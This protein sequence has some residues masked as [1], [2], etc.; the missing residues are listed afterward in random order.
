MVLDIR[1]L[2]AQFGAEI[3]GYDLTQPA[4][5]LLGRIVDAWRQARVVVLRG[6]GHAS[7]A[8]LLQFSRALGRLD[9]APNFDTEKSS[10]DGFAEIAVVSNIKREG[11]PLGG[12]GDGELAWHSD[13]TYVSDPP[14]ACALLARELPE[15]GS[16]DTWFL[17]LVGAYEALPLGLKSTIARHRLFHDAGYTSA[18]TLRTNTKAGA[19]NWHPVVRAEPLSGRPALFLGRTLNRRVENLEASAGHA[20]LD[21]LWLH[22]RQPQ[23]TLQHRWQPGDLLLWNNAA[24]MHRRDAFDSTQRRRLHRT[25]IRSLHAHWE[26]FASVA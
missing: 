9:P 19:G 15:D 24:V 1:P 14:V 11:K 7:D 22:A 5:R 13:M 3:H 10:L 25:Q 12:L 2:T 26:P 17:D 20:L 4:D 8:D 16:G 21:E 23:F 18:G 6:Q